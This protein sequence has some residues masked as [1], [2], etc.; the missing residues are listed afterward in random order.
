VGYDHLF[1]QHDRALLSDW[2]QETGELYVDLHRPHSGGDNSS[3]YFTS[4]LAQLKEIVVS[5]GHPEVSITIFRQKQYAIRGIADEKLAHE[6]LAL[7]PEGEWFSILSLEKVPSTPW[8]VIGSGNTHAELQ[9]SLANLKGQSIRFGRNPFDLRSSYFEDPDDA[10]VANSYL[11]PPKITKNWLSYS[12][13][14][15]DPDRYRDRASW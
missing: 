13:F 8:N 10:W 6:A 15:T 1:E 7:I 2:L 4:T 5:E 3:F 11:H 9:E 12:P 14:E